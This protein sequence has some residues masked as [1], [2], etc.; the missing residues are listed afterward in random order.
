MTDQT[1]LVRS[2]L[3]CGAKKATVIS[4]AQIVLSPTFRE[5]CKSNQ[6]GGYGNC[7]MCPPYIG[8][9]EDLMEEV[10]S[11]P[12]GVWYQTVYPLEDSFDIEGMFEAGAAHARVS[13]K[14]QEAVKPLLHGPFLHLT[15]GGCH[16][17]ETCAAREHKPCRM[18]DKALSSLEGYGFDVYKTT[19]DTGLAYINGADTVTYFGIVLFSE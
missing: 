4:Q 12:H 17:C 14:I 15:C 6:C 18:P 9:I 13:Q 5:I 1:R 7:W 8:K 3:E 10:R 19:K 16:L 11:Y 2:V